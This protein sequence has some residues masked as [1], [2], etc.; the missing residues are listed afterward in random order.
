MI[1]GLV[2]L[3]IR[4]H[5]EMADAARDLQDRIL[6]LGRAHDYVRLYKGHGM[7][8]PSHSSL[9]GMLDE[10]LRP[11][12]NGDSTRITVS[13]QDLRIDD[14]SA[15]PLALFF[16]ELATNAAKYG[17]LSQPGGRVAILIELGED[18]V[19]RWAERGGP[20]VASSPE[21]GFGATLVQMS[22]GRQLG[23]SLDMDWLPGGIV[24]E[25]RIPRSAM[26]R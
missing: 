2:S 11:Y 16:H 14:R 21:R 24:V 5:P 1:G 25:A 8:R 6:A 4:E 22:I 9:R 13:G 7:S 26:A 12:Q 23:G 20:A 18:V 19:L 17:A 15:T 3:T 10:L